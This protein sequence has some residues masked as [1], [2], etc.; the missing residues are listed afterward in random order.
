MNFVF[1]AF[2]FFVFIGPL[3]LCLIANE[4]MHGAEEEEEADKD[5][6]KEERKKQKM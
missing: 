1:N 5:D 6:E 2:F 4:P 3:S